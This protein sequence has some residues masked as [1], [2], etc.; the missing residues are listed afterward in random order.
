MPKIKRRPQ[1]ELE[2]ITNTDLLAERD[3]V[4]TLISNNQF[5]LIKNYKS[6]DE[7]TFLEIQDVLDKV[8]P[9]EQIFIKNYYSLPSELKADLKIVK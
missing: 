3:T 1:Q 2:L 8:T 5:R 4:L 9:L 7:S 6:S